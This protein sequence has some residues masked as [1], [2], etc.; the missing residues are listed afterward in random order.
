[1]SLLFELYVSMGE[2]ALLA[3]LEIT[4]IE[5]YLPNFQIDNIR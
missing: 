1:M 2:C 3:Q 4:N 5:V